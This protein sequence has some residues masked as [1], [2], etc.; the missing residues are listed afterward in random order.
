MLVCISPCL[1]IIL[2][3]DCSIA[4]E[5]V[6]PMI[7]RRVSGLDHRPEWTKQWSES[8]RG[9]C[10]IITHRIFSSSKMIAILAALAALLAPVKADDPAPGWMV[11]KGGARAL[12]WE[13]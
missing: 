6:E 9:G 8:G 10:A 13:S 5:I 1:A 7:Q 11:S 4:D 2:P 12:R 3:C